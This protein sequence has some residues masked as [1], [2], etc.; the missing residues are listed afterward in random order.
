[1]FGLTE[2]QQ[3]R[4]YQEV[5]EE[6]KQEVKQEF[7]EEGK[8]ESVPGLLKMGLSVEQIA[9]ALELKVEVVR[10]AV[11]QQEGKES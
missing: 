10:K 11:E 9:Q 4:F 6:I 2:W 7:K 5:K 8:L 1:M 3:T